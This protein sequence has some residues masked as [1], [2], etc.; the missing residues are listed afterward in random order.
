MIIEPI[1]NRRETKKLEN[2]YR[3]NI[4]SHFY[5]E[6]AKATGNRLAYMK[7]LTYGRLFHRQLKRQQQ[8]VYVDKTR[9]GITGKCS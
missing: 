9:P 3:S 8:N 5:R 2:V 6:L 4:S 7:A 1:N